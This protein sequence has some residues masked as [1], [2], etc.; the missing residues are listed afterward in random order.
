MTR[1][2]P[3]LHF[4]ARERDRP[5]HG[6]ISTSAH[7]HI[8]TSTPMPTE[9]TPHIS[10]MYRTRPARMSKTAPH[11]SIPLWFP[12]IITFTWHDHLDHTHQ[13]PAPPNRS[14]IP[15]RITPP[16]HSVATSART[17]KTPPHTRSTLEE[18]HLHPWSSSLRSTTLRHQ[19]DHTQSQKSTDHRYDD[20]ASQRTDDGFSRSDNSSCPRCPTMAMTTTSSSVMEER[21]RLLYGGLYDIMCVPARSRGGLC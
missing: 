16:L 17:G 1:V 15:Q 8:N 9:N 11:A 14:Q 18:H 3:G 7:Q 21:G 13:L 2:E 12:G 6:P 19:V 5:P 20:A 10:N 4:S